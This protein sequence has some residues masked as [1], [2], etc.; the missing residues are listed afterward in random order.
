M[1][2]PTRPKTPSTL[3]REAQG[4]WR[5]LVEEYALDD[6]AG[7]LLLQTALEAFDR[8]RGAQE[9][10]QSEGATVTDRF[11]QPKP[12]P[13]TVIERDSRAGMM[14]ALRAL[15]LDIEPLNDRPGRPAGR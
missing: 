9:L 13:A 1:K 14:A 11:G 10:I 8:M 4:W 3:S 15:N 6:P 5:K 7:L 12:H 2:N